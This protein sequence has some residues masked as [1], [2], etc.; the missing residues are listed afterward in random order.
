M[1]LTITL[2][3]KEKNLKKIH[4]PFYFGILSAFFLLIDPALAQ[5]ATSLSPVENSASFILTFLT[6][7]F[8]RTIAIIAVAVLGFTGLKGRIG[9]PIAGG[10]IFFI[11]CVFGGATL[12]DAFIAAL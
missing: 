7:T 2:T 11:F 8:A 6:G 1:S 9:W 10:I 4:I 12:V 5:T 3:K